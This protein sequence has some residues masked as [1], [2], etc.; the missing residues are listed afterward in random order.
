MVGVIGH[1]DHGKTAL[2]RALT[3]TETDR[4]AEEKARGISIALGFAHLADDT[5]EIDLIDMP[6]HERFV[7][8]MIAGATGIDAVV[9]VVAANEGVKPQTREHVEIAGLLGITRAV[10]AVTKCDLVPTDEAMLV[11]GETAELLRANG[12]EEISGGSCLLTSAQTGFGI[13]GLAARLLLIADDTPP[14]SADGTLWLPIDRAFSMTG[15]GA[16]V[17]GTLRGAAVRP[18]DSLTLH[19]SCKQVRVRGVQV[20]GTPVGTAQPGQRTAVNLRDVSASELS[21]GMALALPEALVTSEW[22]TLALRSVA[23]APA[24]ANGARLRALFGTA[25]VDVRL[26]LLDRDVLEPGESCLAQVHL[27]EP[28][29]VPAREPVILRVAS[30]A[31]TVAGGRVIEPVVR[32]RRRHDPIGL[33]RLARLCNLAPAELVVA[34]AGEADTTL[35]DLA[36]LSALSPGRIAELLGALPVTVTRS[37]VV[38]RE[39]ELA[40]LAERLPALIGR[41]PLGLSRNRLASLV[42]GTRAAALDE[43]LRRLMAAGSVARR[44]AQFVLPAADADRAREAGAAGLAAEIAELL[45]LA[46]LQPPNP[47][48]IVTDAARARALDALLKQGTVIRAVDRAKRREMLFHSDAIAEARR[49]LGPLLDATG[50]GLLV[51]EISA[52]LGI[53]RKFTMP[54][55]DH[56]DTIRFTRRERDRR[57]SG[58]QA[59]KIGIAKQG[60]MHKVR[61]DGGETEK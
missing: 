23:S 16:V 20:H 44:G 14:R 13:P 11:A 28:T 48:A 51:S 49:R 1:V 38:L 59:R 19:P 41:E 7:R 58:L 53:T 60:M 56:L 21:R 43:A 35:A 45:R 61:L 2:V 5:R 4:L 29:A 52:A 6:G 34:E 9:L 39:A 8:T 26:R 31:Q 47:S 24:L 12:F 50:E 33:A 30:P 25:E 54:L 57:V 15:H 55:V 42:P 17:T 27:A 40:R 36:R 10:V 37:G 46:G 18:G 32:R 22:L 3:G